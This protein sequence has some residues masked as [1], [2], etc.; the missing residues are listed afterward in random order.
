[1]SCPSG[2]LGNCS[3][4]LPP[5]NY[6]TLNDFL[7]SNWHPIWR[8]F[9]HSQFDRNLDWQDIIPFFLWII[10]NARNSNTFDDKKNPPNFNQ[11]YS[12]TVEYKHLTKRDD[13]PQISQTINIKW[14][15]LPI[16]TS[17][18]T[19]M[20]RAW[21]IQERGEI[22]GVIRTCNGG[23]VMGF[24]KSFH[25]ATNN[26]MELMTLIE[27][28]NLVEQHNLLPIEITIDSPEIIS[29]LTNG[30]SIIML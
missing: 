10:W 20:A 6:T 3:P 22:R 1:M 18:L 27:G 28:L 8:A 4:R 11:A 16:T 21:E 9:Q 17:S 2:L 7:P 13:C 12:Q 23:W 14:N 26:M 15:P 29:M 5:S 19:P 24:Y 25:K 30:I